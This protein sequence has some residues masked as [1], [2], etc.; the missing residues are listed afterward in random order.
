[1]T[2][3]GVVFLTTSNTIGTTI[4]PR[5]APNVRGEIENHPHSRKCFSE[6]HQFPTPFFAQTVLGAIFDDGMFFELAKNTH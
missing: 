1:M 4:S 3:L 2:L 5:M 6:I